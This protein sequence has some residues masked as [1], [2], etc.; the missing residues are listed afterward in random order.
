MANLPLFKSEDQMLMLM[1]TKWKSQLDKVI[2]N[3]FING[4][5]LEDVPL[6]IGDNI[7]NHLLS[8]VQQGWV[9]TDQNA[10]ITIYRNA[11]FNVRTLTLNSSGTVTVD[12][13]VF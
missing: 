13:W 1:Q 8:R 5:L 12:I 4:L 10:G 11:P 2:S 9:L 6:V 3:P 7:I